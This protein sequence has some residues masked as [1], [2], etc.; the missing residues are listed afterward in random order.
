MQNYV[1]QWPWQ[2]KCKYTS[3]RPWRVGLA[4]KY[5][6]LYDRPKYMEILEKTCDN[7]FSEKRVSKKNQCHFFQEAVMFDG[8]FVYE[9]W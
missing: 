5:T 6:D 7:H 8:L 3:P 4:E 9:W 1:N 2:E